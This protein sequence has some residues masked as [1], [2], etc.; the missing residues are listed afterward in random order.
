MKLKLE[1]AGTLS[2]LAT[3]IIGIYMRITE[4]DVPP[5]IYPI[6]VGSA[7]NVTKGVININN[8]LNNQVIPEEQNQ[9]KW[10]DKV[11]NSK[12]KINEISV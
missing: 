1:I 4:K 3:L 6:I 7:V 2:S 11:K 8:E 9:T 12:N 10:Q 5:I